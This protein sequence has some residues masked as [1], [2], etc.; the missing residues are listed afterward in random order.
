MVRDG[1]AWLRLSDQNA[2]HGLSD[3]PAFSAGLSSSSERRMSNFTV[4]MN[5]AYRTAPGG[6]DCLSRTPRIRLPVAS[7][8]P[9]ETK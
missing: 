7:S 8:S 6:S 1:E 5:Q 2:T 4:Y 9:T 3:R